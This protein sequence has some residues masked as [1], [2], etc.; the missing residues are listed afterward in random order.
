MALPN[1]V[2]AAVAFVMRSWPLL[3]KENILPQIPILKVL[4][5]D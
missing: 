5:T 1:D 4:K 2:S 3:A